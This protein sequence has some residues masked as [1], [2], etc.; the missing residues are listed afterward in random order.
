MA[1]WIAGLKYIT[2]MS[3]ISRLNFINI[4]A[5]EFGQPAILASAKR[6][7]NSVKRGRVQEQHLST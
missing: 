1:V 5:Y 4:Y 3:E 2:L 7:V 6:A